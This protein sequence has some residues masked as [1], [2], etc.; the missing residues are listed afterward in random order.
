MIPM[1]RLEQIS[2]RFEFLEASMSAGADGA[3]F[4]ALAKE[5]ADLKPVVEQVRAYKQ[6]L[7]DLDEAEAMLADPEMAELA[8]EELPGLKAGD[9]SGRGGF[10]DCPA[11]QGCRRCQACNAGNPAWHGR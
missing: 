4:A 11:A 10:A 5:Y 3:D 2:Q 7:T 6:L 8:R 9:T 1:D